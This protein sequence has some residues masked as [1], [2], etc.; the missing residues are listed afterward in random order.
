MLALQRLGKVGRYAE[1]VMYLREVDRGWALT[2]L[3]YALGS[4]GFRVVTPGGTALELDREGLRTLIGGYLELRRAFGPGVADAALES[5]A[6]EAQSPLGAVSL[7]KLLGLLNYYAG[8]FASFASRGYE[9]GVSEK[10]ALVLRG[11][12]VSATFKA[13]CASYSIYEVFGDFQYDVADVISNIRGRGVVDIGANVGDSA[14]YFALRGASKVVAVEP[15]PNVARC[16]QENVA[17][18]KLEDRVKVVNAAVGSD[19]AVRV[20]CGFPVHDSGGFSTLSAQGEC[21][22]PSVRLAELVKEVGDPYLLKVDCEGCE[23]RLIK[24]ELDS[25]A[26]FEHVIVEFHPYITK[27]PNEELLGLLRSAGFRCKLH[28]ALGQVDMY[29]C[30]KDSSAGDG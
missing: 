9:V 26:E 20:P 1:A 13:S 23:A 24:G 14:I 6:S 18:N 15:L 30:A 28:R 3:H 19:G 5:A 2:L 17:L 8:L 25:V 29:H 16:A 11:H 4:R 21:E 12:G 22:V 10:G 27:V 7:L